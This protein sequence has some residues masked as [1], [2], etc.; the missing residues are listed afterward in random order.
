MHS[1]WRGL[2][3][4]VLALVLGCL[5]LVALAQPAIASV[6]TYHEQPGQT[7][8]RSRQSLRDQ[9]DLAWQATVFKRYSH[10]VFQGTYLRLVGFPGQV[11]IAPVAD[12]AIE[13]GTT[14][15]WRAPRQLDPQ[16]Q[17]LPESVAQY[18]LGKVLA[19][20][21]QPI[22]LTLLVPLQGGGA[23][24]LVAAPYVVKEWL[25]IYAMNDR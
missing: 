15:R 14:A 17:Q 21:T 22:P 20:L 9:T 6:H 2:K 12:L 18:G 24:R 11:A 1:L 7:T 8:Y 13:T 10:G 23:A 16:T 25:Q 19:E 4:L 5:L 3:L